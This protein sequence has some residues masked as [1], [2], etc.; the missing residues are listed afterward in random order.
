MR[1]TERPTLVQLIETTI[2]GKDKNEIDHEVLGTTDKTTC[3]DAAPLYEQQQSDSLH[4]ATR[5]VKVPTAI[6]NR[7][8]TSM[9]RETDTHVKGHEELRYEGNSKS[10]LQIQVATYVFE[11]SAGNCH[12]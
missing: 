6:V 5:H 1:L 4:M 11:L 3:G 12:R 2:Q 7:K 8:P 10:K 9:C